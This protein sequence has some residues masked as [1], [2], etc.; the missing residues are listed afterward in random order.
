VPLDPRPVV[1]HDAELGFGGPAPLGAGVVDVGRAVPLPASG[2]DADLVDDPGRT[3]PVAAGPAERDDVGEHMGQRSSDDLRGDL[4]RWTDAGLIDQ[5]QADA[6]FAHD[7]AAAPTG[8]VSV[9]A[10]ALGYAGSALALA[11]VITAIGNSWSS[12]GRGGRITAAVVPTLLAVLAGWALRKKTEPAF[13][14][15]M[16]L[17][18]FIAIGG[19][20]GSAAIVISEGWGIDHDW[21]ALA[22]GIAMAVPAFAF[23][24]LHEA[25]LQQ[26]AL[27]G[28]VLVVVLAAMVLAPGEPSGAALMLAT[29]ALG[30]VWVLFGWTKLMEPHRATMVLGAILATYAPTLAA[31]E[32]EWM[33]FVG[34]ATGAAF[35]TLSIPAGIIP[36]LAIG[37][38]GV[39]AYVTAIV[40]RYFGDQL[41]V[42]LALTIIGATFI[43][44]A[45]I[46]ARLGRFGRKAA[47]S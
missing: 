24:R 36:M 4:K 21:T 38:I 42:P 6:I 12:L 15:L 41:G 2:A 1:M 26:V 14:R 30:V 5:A 10:E 37:T 32:H 25:I 33:L 27:L 44:L 13:R 35:M 46:A 28:S 8:G 22:I 29:W 39:F 47:G 23:W 17:L 31:G 20:A 3:D 7:A 34:V 16:S 43:A 40:L 18:W 9:L 11:G 19:F 45:L